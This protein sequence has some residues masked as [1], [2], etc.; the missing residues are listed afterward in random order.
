M[1]LNTLSF[2]RFLNT[3]TDV[4]SV[5]NGAYVQSFVT[6][7]YVNGMGIIA[8]ESDS[9]NRLRLDASAA[10]TASVN[11]A[12]MDENGQYVRNLLGV[13]SCRRLFRETMGCH[14]DRAHVQTVA[15]TNVTALTPGANVAQVILAQDNRV[16]LTGQTDAVQNGVYVVSATGTLVRSSDMSIGSRAAGSVI[17]NANTGA[18]FLC[19][20]SPGADVVGTH[21]LRWQEIIFNDAS[22]RRAVSTGDRAPVAVLLGTHT[23][24]YNAPPQSIAEVPVVVGMRVLL[25]AQNNAVENGIWISGVSAWTRAEDMAAGSHAAGATIPV[26]QTGNMYRCS[27]VFPV[28]I[29]GLHSLSFSWM[30]NTMADVQSVVTPAYVN[31]LGINAVQLNGMKNQQWKV[32]RMSALIKNVEE[33]KS[34]TYLNDLLLDHPVVSYKHLGVFD[35]VYIVDV[36]WG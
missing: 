27:S 13:G 12:H 25:M 1:G 22:L 16:L 19:W 20:S 2:P 28:D 30:V 10:A 23:D 35:C 32:K 6:P 7:A 26:T 24:I 34:F 5:I 15:N 31:A 14:G 17:M 21:A 8:A 4:Q 18:R 33:W 29:V 36:P 11:Q 9:A 3:V